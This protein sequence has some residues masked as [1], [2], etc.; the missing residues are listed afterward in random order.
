M[1]AQDRAYAYVMTA[2]LKK[3]N[4]AAC[5]PPTLF[6]QNAKRM[7]H[8]PQGFDQLNPEQKRGPVTEAIRPLTKK[9]TLIG[10]SESFK[11][12]KN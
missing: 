11:S 5:G 9:T 6:A 8:P 12:V 1:S 10:R 3:T 2:N 4:S 7:G